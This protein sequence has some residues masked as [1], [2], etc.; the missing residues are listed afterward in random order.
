MDRSK[1]GVARRL[2]EAHFRIEPEIGQIFRLLATDAVESQEQE[3]VKL[4]EVNSSTPK[5]GIMPV[6]FAAHPTSGIF[7]PAVIVEIH[8]DEM[9]ELQRNVLRL[10]DG[11]RIGPEFQRPREA[12]PA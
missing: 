9:A 12:V 10:P 7:F 3:P 2:A 4:L 6:Y 8:P 1:E 11:W 5:T